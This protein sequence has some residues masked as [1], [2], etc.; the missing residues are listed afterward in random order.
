MKKKKRV[1][2]KQGRSSLPVTPDGLPGLHPMPQAY[3][4]FNQAFVHRLLLPFPHLALGHQRWPLK[5]TINMACCC[6]RK[7]QKAVS[8][9]TPK[10][11]SNSKFHAQQARGPVIWIALEVALDHV[12]PC[13]ELGF[14]NSCGS[15]LSQRST[16]DL[17]LH[18]GSSSISS[19]LGTRMAEST[20][21]CALGH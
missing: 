20:A 5:P 12:T 13:C 2:L 9:P 6:F 17:L 3:P 11:W 8:M 10:I 14:R 21:R 4:E 19:S 1:S 18:L 15:S 16:V 7:T